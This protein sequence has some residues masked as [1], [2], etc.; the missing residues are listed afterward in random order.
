M[1]PINTAD[2]LFHDGNEVTG[3]P[4][5]TVTA[6][7]LNSVQ[8]DLISLAGGG[9]KTVQGDYSMTAADGIVRVN[10]PGAPAAIQLPPTA[11]LAVGTRRIVR[12]VAENLVTVSAADG[13]TID[14]QLTAELPAPHDRLIVYLTDELTWETI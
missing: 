7:W 10:S 2:G 8:S 1:I 4:G 13:K 3:E 14:G 5:T 6:A 9:I 12:N 11:G